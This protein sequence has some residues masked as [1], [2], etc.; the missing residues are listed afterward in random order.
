MVLSML[1][2]ANDQLTYPSNPSSGLELSVSLANFSVSLKRRLTDP[3]VYIATQQTGG[4]Q[5]LP[6]GHALVDFAIPSYLREFDEDGNVVYASQ[7]G[8]VNRSDVYRAYKKE[9]VGRP[10]TSPKVVAKPYLSGETQVWVSWNGATEVATWIIY[11]GSSP[12][13]LS[14]KV[15][16]QKVYFETSVKIPGTYGYVQVKALDKNG[17]ALGQSAVVAPQGAQS[18]YERVREL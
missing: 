7:L 15:K 2:N 10:T 1:D 9:W 5:R 13:A 11:A 4:Y 18:T 12:A 3:E 17:Q 8:P 14:E 6:A 16:L